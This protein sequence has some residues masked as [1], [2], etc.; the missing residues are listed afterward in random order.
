[1]S[2]W[3]ALVLQEGGTE[4]RGGGACRSWGSSGTSRAAWQELRFSPEKSQLI[5]LRFGGFF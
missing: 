4:G 3:D 5:E 2:R 1:M